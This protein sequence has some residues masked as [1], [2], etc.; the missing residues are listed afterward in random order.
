M[1]LS[2]DSRRPSL[3]YC[4]FDGDGEVLGEELQKG[5]F[6]VLLTEAGA[7]RARLTVSPFDAQVCAH[8][9]SSSHMIRSNSRSAKATV[10]LM[11]VC[12]IFIHSAPVSTEWDNIHAK[13]PNA[14]NLTVLSEYPVYDSD[15]AAFIVKCVFVIY[16][17]NYIL[18]CFHKRNC[19]NLLLDQLVFSPIRYSFYVFWGVFKQ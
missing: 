9:K 16:E 14:H 11:L 4:M 15:F 19:W 7:W 18:I 8:T 5:C 10:L 17:C 3:L 13:Y 12:L 1:H 6:D 2:E